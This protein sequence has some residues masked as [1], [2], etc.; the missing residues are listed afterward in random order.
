MMMIYS[1]TTSTESS[2]T[3][4]SSGTHGLTVIP[5][6]KT[7]VP[8]RFGSSLKLDRYF[9]LTKAAP[10]PPSIAQ[11][12][13]DS[14]PRAPRVPIACIVGSDYLLTHSVFKFSSGPLHP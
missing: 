3:S 9:K 11:A 13:C 12:P 4:A 5:P 10:F 6:D 1:V 14:R 7:E 8:V 2:S